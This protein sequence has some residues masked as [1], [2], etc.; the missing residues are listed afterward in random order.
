[1]V[2]INKVY[3][4]FEKVGVSFKTEMN[5]KDVSISYVTVMELPERKNYFKNRLN[6]Y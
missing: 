3:E 4:E 1:M 2:E 6:Q 5:D